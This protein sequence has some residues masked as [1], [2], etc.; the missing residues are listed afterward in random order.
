MKASHAKICTTSLLQ[1]LASTIFIHFLDM[2][3][4]A[5]S[6]P[7][8]LAVQNQ[9]EA[10]RRALLCLKSQIH[11]P[12]EALVSWRDNSLAFCEWH[13]VTCGTRHVSRVIALDL[14][15]E[16]ITGEIFPCVAHLS[17]LT[18]IHMPGNHIIG[19]I[20]QEIGQLTRLQYINLS[21]NSIRGERYL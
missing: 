1:L 15:S 20:G 8:T 11:D 10:D 6:I 12:S 19:S 4:H 18:R 16:N 17:F 2:Q 7:M 9:S 5:Y 21:M 3:L 14:E 13:G